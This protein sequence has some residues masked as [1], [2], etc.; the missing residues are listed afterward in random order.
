MEHTNAESKTSGTRG[1]QK[2]SRNIVNPNSHR[3]SELSSRAVGHK[4]FRTSGAN[5]EA[6]DFVNW[7]GGVNPGKILEQLIEECREELAHHVSQ[8][9]KLTERLQGLEELD[10]RL[11]IQDLEK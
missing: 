2:G 1:N 4:S 5:R 7:V 3:R 8:V 6:K 11:T 10:H 9:E